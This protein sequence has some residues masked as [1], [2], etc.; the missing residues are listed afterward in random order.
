MQSASQIPLF[1][2]GG[3]RG[4][5][6]P[7]VILSGGLILDIGEAERTFLYRCQDRFLAYASLL[8]W[9][10]LFL[11]LDETHARLYRKEIEC[12]RAKGEQ[13]AARTGVLRNGAPQQP[14]IV[15]VDIETLAIGAPAD[16]D[17]RLA[18]TD[19]LAAALAGL[20]LNQA[21]PTYSRI[22]AGVSDLMRERGLRMDWDLQAVE[23]A[24]ANAMRWHD[25]A[26]AVSLVEESGR[27]TLRAAHAPT[28]VATLFELSGL[29]NYDE[30]AC[31]FSKRSGIRAPDALFVKSSRNS[32]GN[33]SAVVARDSFA[34]LGDL[35]RTAQREAEPSG[36]VLASM[37]GDLRK[38][39]DAAPTLSSASFPTSALE[40]LVCLQATHRQDLSF[41]IQ[42]LLRPPIGDRRLGG[43]GLSFEISGDGRVCPAV[44]SGQVYRDADQ[45][46]FLGALLSPAVSAGLPARFRD[47]AE[48]LAGLYAERGYRG[49]LSFDVR[50][51]ADGEYRFIHDSNP[52]LTGAFPSLAVA[53]ALAGENSPASSVL[54]LGYRGEFVLDDLSDALDALGACNLLYTRDHP[55]GAVVLPNLCRVNGYDL[56]LVNVELSTIQ[57]LLAPGG[58]IAALSRAD[59]HPRRLFY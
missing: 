44:F 57:E 20:A 21:S 7:L 35:V 47:E 28:A 18:G 36:S 51:D 8:G 6:A 26:A 39:I 32:A 25:K 41:L 31:L 56:H 11:A 17:S 33:L 46:H 38:D 14:L 42:P 22:V 37:I 13:I 3:Q 59:L 34:P 43:L 2:L 10:C 54:T 49:P 55:F 53:A 48:A 50:L 16:F 40:R 9:R 30:L 4:A 15:L 1:R 19:I 58:V 5:R 45:T 24:S 27:S 23:D 12:L 52:R 29:R